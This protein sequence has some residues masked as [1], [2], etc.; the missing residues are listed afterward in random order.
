MSNDE[1]LS[2]VRRVARGE[3]PINNSLA[4]RPQVAEDVLHQFQNLSLRPEEENLVSPLTPREKKILEYVAEGYFNKEIAVRLG[5]SEQT[6]KN[7]VTSIL[8][9]LNANSRTEAVVQ[10]IKQSLISVS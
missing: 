4:T 1:L 3:Y 6:V 2:A 8:R 7:H 9:K 10:A 5:I